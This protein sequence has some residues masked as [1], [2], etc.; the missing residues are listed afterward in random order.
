MQLTEKLTRLA[1][2]VCALGSRSEEDSRQEAGS[3]S[4]LVE[5]HK[6][7]GGR[8]EV[9]MCGVYL[10]RYFPVCYTFCICVSLVSHLEHSC[11]RV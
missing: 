1:Q 3:L 5:G 6:E 11:G 9:N 8:E 2:A 10:A 7:E 4:F